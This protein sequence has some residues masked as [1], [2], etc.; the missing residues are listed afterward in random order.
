MISFDFDYYQAENAEEAVEKYLELK[1]KNKNVAYYNGGTEIV[2]YARKDKMNFDALIDIK[3]IPACK[4]FEDDDDKIVLGASLSLNKVVKENV[5]PL[6]SESSKV[7]AD[8]TTRNQ[9]T[10]GGNLTGRLPF[11]EAL[12]PLLVAEA[13]VTTINKDGFRTRPITEVFDKRMVLDKEEI[14]LQIIIDKKKT[15]LP[16]FQTR[17]V[18]Q[19][20]IDYPVLHIA[21]LKEDNKIKMAISSLCAFPFRNEKIEEVI[22]DN[23]LSFEEKIYQVIENLPVPIS[24]NQRGGKDYKEMLFRNSLG[25]CLKNLGGDNK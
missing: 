2:T 7:I 20:E 22:N 16:Y 25:E 4:S 15:K 18:K 6:L 23:S 24:S 8:H 11:K 12:L 21:A 3:N 9:I 14:L 10:L 19:S 13:E 17:K 1:N 5:F